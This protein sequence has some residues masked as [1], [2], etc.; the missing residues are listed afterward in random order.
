[1]R[2]RFYASEARRIRL[3]SNRFVLSFMLLGIMAVATSATAGNEILAESDAWPAVAENQSPE[4]SPHVILA[5]TKGWDVSTNWKQGC[6]YG[7]C[8][9]TDCEGWTYTSNRICRTDNAGFKVCIS[10]D[11][12]RT[13]VWKEIGGGLITCDTCIN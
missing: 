1:M 4:A 6:Q 5:R 11:Q 2:P 8:E 9:G 10:D 3:M 7:P 13:C 12:N